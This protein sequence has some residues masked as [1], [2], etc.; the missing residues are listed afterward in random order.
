MHNPWKT[1]KSWIADVGGHVL[2][3]GFAKICGEDSKLI[4]SPVNRVPKHMPPEVQVRIDDWFET[5]FG[6]RF[7]QRS[8][9]STGSI[10]IAKQYAQDWGEVRVLRPL[11]TYAFCWSRNSVDLFGEYEEKANGETVE[12]WLDR[13]EFTTDDISGAIE[14]KREVMLVCESVEAKKMASR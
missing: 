3:R 8:I 13:L 10:E 6:V 9:F 2:Y 12:A 5:R 4:S 11:N 14:S 7:R 1:P